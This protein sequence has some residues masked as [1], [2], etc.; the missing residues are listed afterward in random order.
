MKQVF[1][2]LIH[3]TKTKRWLCI[4]EHLE[5]KQTL[6]AQE[7]ADLVGC[8]ERTIRTDIKEM[9]QYFLDTIEL[10]SDE[11]G[12]HFFFQ[13]PRRYFEKKQSLLSSE[14]LFV[15][16]DQILMGVR[17]T[18]QAWAEVLAVGTASFGRIK[19][20]LVSLLKK[21]YQVVIY[22]IDNQLK[23]E[24]SAIRQLMYD[25]Y[26][27]LPIYP[28]WLD[29]KMKRIQF[30]DLSLLSGRWQLDAIRLIRWHQVVLWR[31]AQHCFLPNCKGAKKTQEKLSSAL[32]EQIEL[33][34]PEREKASLFLL[35]LQEEQ[36]LSIDNQ[37]KFIHEFSPCIS[38]D[39][40]EKETQETPAQFFD[41]ILVLFRQFFSITSVKFS[42][43]SPWKSL[44]EQ[45]I[46]DQLTASCLEQKQALERSLILIFDLT[47]SLTLQEWI[48]TTVRQKLKKMG[49]SLFEEDH[50]RPS[51]KQIIITNKQDH[52]IVGTVG[53]P[54]SIPEETEMLRLLEEVETFFSKK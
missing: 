7:L 26:Y 50:T 5:E 32:E 23:G 40:I 22:S 39:E 37:K 3:Q 28:K 45:T 52:Q 4:A 38:K 12:Y 54:S 44:K 16:L 17:K 14:P 13:N 18:N 30:L 9:K 8:T 53:R 48:K 43:E 34:L 51:I 10:I 11:G 1:Y 19:R 20:V 27:R 47:G 6:K 25:F 2:Q 31:M 29:E 36:F 35:A 46:F 21:H 33:A 24:E 49:Y 15:L 42:E 41:T